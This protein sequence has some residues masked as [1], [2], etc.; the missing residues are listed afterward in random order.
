MI[1]YAEALA[2]IRAHK[3]LLGTEAIALAEIAGRI[4]AEKIT[5]PI[6]NQPFDNS[7]MDGFALRTEEIAAAAAD[8]PVVLEMTGHI[9]AGGKLATSAPARGQC[10]EIMTGAPLPPGCDAVV[11][12]EKTEKD[13]SGRILFRAPAQKGD[14]IRRAGADFAVGDPVLEPGAVLH[15]G[16]VL[17]LATLGIGAV[18]VVRRPKVA[19]VSTGL[20]VVD[21]LGSAL[22][23]GQIYNSTGPYLLSILPQ[24]GMK[25]V[26]LGTVADDA[27]LYKQKLL[28]AA[29]DGCD[30]IL[31]TGAV[32]A[33]VHDFVPA[34]L[35]D[36]G[37]EI[38][39]HKVAIRPG[40]PVLFAKFP[41]GGPF[42]FGL[43]GNPVSTAVGLRFFVCPLL[44]EMQNLPPEPPLC[45]V[46]AE[47]YSV[48]AAGLRFFLRAK[49]GNNAKGETVAGII[50]DQQ[51]FKVSP[52]V[53]S[54]AWVTV[55][56]QVS[57]LK[58]GDIV[59]IYR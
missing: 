16:H 30:M 52:F 39:F 43:P 19:L 2:I 32:S 1:S 14:N 7:A 48:K 6:A 10:Y 26:A 35:K 37:A 45:G 4:C 40:K 42:F 31:S 22:E 54:D 51:S 9:A 18:K 23:G 8:T 11:P 25:P 28:A 29:R 15:V 27:A 59:E 57:Q 38:F 53:R 41:H 24:M 58:A 17:A 13:K 33:G 47:D 20:E 49:L 36:I 21:D 44:R 46:L 3:N 5:A 50:R 56:E 55:P 34:V 12:V